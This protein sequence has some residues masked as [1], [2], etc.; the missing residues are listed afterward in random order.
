VIGIA[1]YQ[2]KLFFGAIIAISFV[3]SLVNLIIA[4]AS[5]NAKESQNAVV[6][7]PNTDK[8]YVTNSDNE[9]ISVID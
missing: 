8:V 4:P 5:I 3:I 2:R 7:N 1:K 6:I 9:S